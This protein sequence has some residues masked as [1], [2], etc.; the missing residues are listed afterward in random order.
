M[1]KLKITFMGNAQ[2]QEVL[3]HALFLARQGHDVRLL[4]AR[5]PMDPNLVREIKFKKLSSVSY[6]I[7][8]FTFVFTALHMLTHRPDLIHAFNLSDYG[9]L[10]SLFARL[11]GM[12]PLILTAKGKDVLEDAKTHQGWAIKHMMPLGALFLSADEMAAQEMIKMGAPVDKIR[13]LES[14]NSTKLA[15]LENMYLA[16]TAYKRKLK[17]AKEEKKSP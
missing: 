7:T 8:Y 10:G 14:E 2:D 16:L 9:V 17:E 12:K 13:V 15:E 4:S 3:N 1:E 5:R 6:P 11:T